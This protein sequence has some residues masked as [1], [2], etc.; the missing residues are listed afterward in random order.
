MK[1]T[2]SFHRLGPFIARQR[3]VFVPA[4]EYGGKYIAASKEFPRSQKAGSF[5]L[6]QGLEKL[7]SAQISGK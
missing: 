1:S 7:Q 2:S 6:D 5:S 4:Q 3:F